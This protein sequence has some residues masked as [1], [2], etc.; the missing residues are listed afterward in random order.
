MADRAVANRLHRSGGIDFNVEF[1]TR[2][3]AMLK[4]QKNPDGKR[5]WTDTEKIS[6]ASY[7]SAYQMS[8]TRNT[9]W[10]QNDGV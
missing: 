5:I 9:N 8:N 2:H 4:N 7:H 6:S 3:A 10:R 1:A